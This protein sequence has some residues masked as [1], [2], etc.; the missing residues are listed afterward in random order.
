MANDE[1]PPDYSAEYSRGR[2]DFQAGRQLDCNSEGQIAGWH[3]AQYEEEQEQA[4]SKPR[5]KVG[6]AVGSGGIGMAIPYILFFILILAAVVP[7]VPAAFLAVWPI[8]WV[9]SKKREVLRFW[10]A[11]KLTFKSLTVYGAITIF[12]LL[13]WFL[14]LRD[15]SFVY[16]QMVNNPFGRRHSQVVQRTAASTLSLVLVL[17]GAQIPGLLAS[18]SMLQRRLSTTYGAGFKGFLRA[19]GITTLLFPA[20]T[21]LSGGILIL[22]AYFVHVATTP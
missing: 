4:S 6:S 20:S 15:A 5:G 10:K 11:W 7:A 16:H 12:L 13:L 14:F 18:A 21:A 2:I 9:S 22:I 8:R 19:T 3:A 1:D 17:V